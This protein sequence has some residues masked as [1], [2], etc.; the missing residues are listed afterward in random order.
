MQA[1]SFND[2]LILPQ[3]SSVKSRKDCDTSTNFLGEQLTTP[4]MSSNMDTVT[5]YRMAT[6]M[7]KAGGIGCLHRFMTIE[8]NIEQLLKSPQGTF[9]SVGVGSA[10]L[11]RAKALYD[12]NAYNF[13]IDVAHGASTQVVA[14]YEK[15]REALPDANIVVGNFAT[16]SS[17][18]EFNKLS[19]Y[20]LQAIKVGVGSGSHCTTRIVTGCGLPTLQS[21]LDCKSLGIPMIADGGIKNSGD[22][23]KALAAG[24]SIVMLGSLLAGT[25]EAPGA[26]YN[27]NNEIMSEKEYAEQIGSEVYLKNP[28]GLIATVNGPKASPGCKITHKKYRGSASKESYE[29]Q[30]KT[31]EHRTAEG[32]SS[33][34]PYKGPV[35]N[36]VQ[37]LT[38]GL[39]SVMSYVGASN[40]EEFQDKAILVEVSHSSYLEGTPHGKTT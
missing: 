29:V 13:I 14:M 36:V 21:L 20:K 2:T 12:N 38:A 8:E 10:E 9:V 30:G 16:A 19:R 1:K 37:G 15:M 39:K 32:E 3:F 34:V 31:A 6:A 22:I 35:V 25:E 18:K 40:L 17:V 4:I 5:E 28:Q 27:F 11:E 7:E 26:N 24:A 33:F 23:A